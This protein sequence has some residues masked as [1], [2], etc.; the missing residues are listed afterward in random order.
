MRPRNDDA[1]FIYKGRSSREFGLRILNDMSLQVPEYDI[2]FVEIPGRDGDL[3]LDNKRYK[4]VDR[5]FR[6]HLIP[7]KGQTLDQAVVA[8]AAWLSLQPGYHKLQWSGE[9]GYFWQAIYVQGINIVESLRQF[10]AVELTFRCQPGKYLAIGEQW[11]N[12]PPGE[13][14][15][16]HNPGNLPAYPLWKAPAENGQAERRISITI[17][18]TEGITFVD[19]QGDISYDAGSHIFSGK[20][21]E[22]IYRRLPFL[23]A[24]SAVELTARGGPVYMQPRWRV[25]G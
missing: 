18:R 24:A 4:S 14:I 1:Y 20:A 3:A 15:T 22:V 8:I 6:C 21:D 11:V 25:L 17:N 13:K 10:G 16:L 7:P 19:A 5:S 23:P 9:P 12:L 2:E